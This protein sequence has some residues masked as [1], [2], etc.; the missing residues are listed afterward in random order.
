MVSRGRSFLFV[1]WIERGRF[2]GCRFWIY[3]S[4]TYRFEDIDVLV[5][6]EDFAFK[7]RFLGKRGSN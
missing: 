5:F 2:S 4:I 1:K 3:V 6:K 7:S